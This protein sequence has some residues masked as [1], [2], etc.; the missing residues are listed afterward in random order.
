[1][2][3][4]SLNT[5]T[6]FDETCLHLA[7][8]WG[9]YDA[10]KLLITRVNT[11]IL[12]AIDKDEAIFLKHLLKDESVGL[13]EELLLKGPCSNAHNYIEV[14]DQFV[15]SAKSLEN[16]DIIDVIVRSYLKDKKAK[17]NLMLLE[18]A[19]TR[20][21]FAVVREFIGRYMREYASQCEKTGETMLHWLVKNGYLEL[22]KQVTASLSIND[23]IF[24]Q[25]DKEE[26]LLQWASKHNQMG[27]AEWILF[28]KSMEHDD[29]ELDSHS[30]D[31]SCD[32]MK[33]QIYHVNKE[34]S[35]LFHCMAANGNVA[36]LKKVALTVQTRLDMQTKNGSTVMHLAA[37]NKQVETAK[38]LL[39]IK[40]YD[41]DKYSSKEFTPTPL[42]IVAENGCLEIA[43][44]LVQNAPQSY[45]ECVEKR[46]KSSALY[47]ATFHGHYELL[48][49]LLGYCS[50]EHRYKQVEL[51]TNC[52]WS[53]IHVAC[54]KGYVKCLNKLL[55]DVPPEPREYV[56]NMG[57]ILNIACSKG[58]LEMVKTI[59]DGANPSIV[60]I[61]NTQGLFPMW[62]VARKGFTDILRVLVEAFGIEVTF[63]TKSKMF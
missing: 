59:I 8:K 2:D 48:C 7:A 22:I 53:P 63:L 46:Q 3:V 47:T 34:G 20:A 15:R 49:L 37:K 61:P 17:L 51:Y 16:Q 29:R 12:Y 52:S 60:S 27:I 31:R 57:T 39:S 43:N 13:L 23:W 9:H 55:E 21:S 11:S 19:I 25:T 14:Y 50:L 10:L 4:E 45:I 26:T 36:F 56:S 5:V 44:L 35:N 30:V 54:V 24:G 40:P 1:M 58:N 41:Y 33:K 38:W 62:H 18:I 28:R 6:N 32:M 42:H